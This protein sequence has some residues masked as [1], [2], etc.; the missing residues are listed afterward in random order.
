MSEVHV[1]LAQ[2]INQTRF[3]LMFLFNHIGCTANDQSVTDDFRTDREVNIQ[4]IKS[5]RRYVAIEVIFGLLFRNIVTTHYRSGIVSRPRVRHRVSLLDLNSRNSSKCFF[6]SA[7]MAILNL[8]LENYHSLR[9]AFRKT[10]KTTLHSN[11]TTRVRREC[12]MF[13]I[14]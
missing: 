11:T 7:K 1:G 12:D 3:D 5:L 9:R 4:L 6:P 2:S 8:I 10:I 13:T 14:L